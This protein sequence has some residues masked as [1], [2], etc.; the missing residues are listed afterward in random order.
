M[1]QPVVQVAW[2]RSPVVAVIALHLVVDLLLI[3][4]AWFLDGDRLLLAVALPFS[5]CSLAVLWALYRAPNPFLRFAVPTLTF[6]L[7]WQVLAKTLSW[8]LE[9]KASAA[10]AVLLAVQAMTLLVLCL[11]DRILPPLMGRGRTTVETGKAARWSFQLQTLI[12]WT[13]VIGLALGFVQ[14]GRAYWGWIVNWS[15]STSIGFGEYARVTSSIGLFNASLAGLWMW[16]L[17]YDGMRCVLRVIVAAVASAL[18]ARGLS[19]LIDWLSAS[20]GLGVRDT[21]VL[22]AWQ[23]LLIA[24]SILV[25]RTFDRRAAPS[26][27]D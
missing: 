18:M 8:G 7:G 23:S 20:L 10:F 15:E 13:T 22:A 26:A 21:M 12:L 5:Q 9:E 24:G 25:V 3:S 1:N 19:P 16:A 14:Y 17:S 11:L 2:V 6:A 4:R 27:E